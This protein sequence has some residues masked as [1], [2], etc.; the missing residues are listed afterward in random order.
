MD[1]DRRIVSQLKLVGVGPRTRERKKQN[2]SIDVLLT[3]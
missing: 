3:Q 2:N 1:A